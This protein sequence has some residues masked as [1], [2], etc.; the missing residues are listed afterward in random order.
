MGLGLHYDFGDGLGWGRDFMMTLVVGCDFI[1][2]F[3][4]LLSSQGMENIFIRSLETSE[5]S[6]K[7]FFCFLQD[8][9]HSNLAMEM[10][11]Y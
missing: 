5:D 6:R 8:S 4:C 7:A 10:A 2:A 3:C 9:H 11:K 1:V